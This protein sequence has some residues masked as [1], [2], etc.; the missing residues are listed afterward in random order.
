EQ[1][2]RN[3]NTES[4]SEVLL[5]VF[6]HELDTQKSLAPDSVFRAM[7][8]VYRRIRGGYAVVMTVLGLG[9][10]AFRD[11]NGIRPLVLGKRETEAGDEYAVAS[12]SVALDLTGFQR[13]RDVAPGEAVVIT[14]DGQLHT[15]QCAE[16]QSL[17]PCIFEFVYLARPDSMMDDISVHKARMRMGVK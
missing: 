12:E 7:E 4:D 9:V 14:L 15:R 2:R 11:P 6:A 1:D 13:V 5:N 17:S 10:V 16:P 8:G 3:V